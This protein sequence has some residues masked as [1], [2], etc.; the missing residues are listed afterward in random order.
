MR[1]KVIWFDFLAGDLDINP[2]MSADIEIGEV[3]L[4]PATTLFLRS[5]VPV[6]VS[7]SYPE[8]NKVLGNSQFQTEHKVWN[9]IP[10]EHST[11]V[12]VTDQNGVMYYSPEVTLPVS[13]GCDA[14]ILNFANGELT[15]Q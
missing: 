1:L 12:S 2:L 6:Q 7:V 14:A 8:E 9:A 13:N 5:D 3:P 4:W 15:W 10:L 11:V